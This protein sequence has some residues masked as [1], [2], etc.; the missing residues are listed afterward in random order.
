MHNVFS[1]NSITDAL[2]STQRD[3]EVRG[4]SLEPGWY[5]ECVM[6]SN[7]KKLSSEHG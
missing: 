4:G 1:H 6:G 5:A 2:K 7:T 3:H